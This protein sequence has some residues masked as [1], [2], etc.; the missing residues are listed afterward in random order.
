[1]IASNKWNNGKEY[2]TYMI[3]I[4]W[5]YKVLIPILMESLSVTGLEAS[6][7]E[8]RSIR[9]WILATAQGSVKVNTSSVESLMK[10]Q[11]WPK[12]LWQLMKPWAEVLHFYRDL[13]SIPD[14]LPEFYYSVSNYLHYTSIEGLI[15]ILIFGYQNFIPK[16]QLPTIPQTQYYLTACWISE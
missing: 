9:K 7:H 16:L 6:C 8:S 3:I 1:M 4:M 14:H 13:I 12:P 2:K 15:A 10:S 5:L 11:F